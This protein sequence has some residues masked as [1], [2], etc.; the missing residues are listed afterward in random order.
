MKSTPTNETD[1]N[2]WN[3]HHQRMKPTP[4]NE[5]NTDILEPWTAKTSYRLVQSLGSAV[6]ELN[7]YFIAV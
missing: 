5:T 2:E 1:T 3:Q 6:I 7:W 4:T